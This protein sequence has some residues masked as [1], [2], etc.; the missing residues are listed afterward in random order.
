M[1]V[2]EC[3]TFIIKVL[4]DRQVGLEVYWRLFDALAHSTFLIFLEKII[5]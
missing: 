5:V 4:E 2:V 1:G 3:K